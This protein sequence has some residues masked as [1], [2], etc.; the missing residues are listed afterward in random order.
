MGKGRK[1]SDRQA[2]S[3]ALRDLPAE[4]KSNTTQFVVTAGR[5]YETQYVQNS[6]T[7]IE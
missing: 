1:Q 6:M 2:N 7:V 4:H 3:W 5:I